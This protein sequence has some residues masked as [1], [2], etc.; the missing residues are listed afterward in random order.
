MSTVTLRPVPFP[1]GVLRTE[2]CGREGK[3]RFHHC[4]SDALLISSDI[5]KYTRLHRTSP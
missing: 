4:G 2:C 3:V 1:T 5:N